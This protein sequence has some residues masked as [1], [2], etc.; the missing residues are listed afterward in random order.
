MFIHLADDR[1]FFCTV[2]SR[3]TSFLQVI[4]QIETIELGHK[5]GMLTRPSAT[6]LSLTNHTTRL[7]WARQGCSALVIFYYS[8]EK[9]AFQI[10][11]TR[12]PSTIL[13]PWLSDIQQMTQ[14]KIQHS[15]GNLLTDKAVL[16][17]RVVSCLQSA[18]VPK[19][20][21]TL[22]DHRFIQKHFSSPENYKTFVSS[23]L[24]DK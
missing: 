19:L 7:V 2:Q 5:K 11:Q 8:V 4:Y 22:I 16:L 24:N 15:H 12:Y 14:K 18:I 23:W 9:R 6:F 1:L 13:T 21:V 10:P 3:H 20:I 17:S